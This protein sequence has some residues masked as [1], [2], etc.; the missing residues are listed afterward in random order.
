[1]DLEIYLEK[2]VEANAQKYFET[3]KKLRKKLEGAGKAI[4]ETRKKLK[5][6]AQELENAE[7][8][9]ERQ[10]KEK[11]RKKEW[12][13]K[14]RWFKSSNDFLIIGGKD[15]TSNEIVI[16]KHTDPHD[17]VFHTEAPG[18]PF[19]VIKNPEKRTIQEE[20]KKEAAIF[21]ATFSRAWEKGMKRAE[22]FEVKPE[23]VSKEAKSGEYITKGAF[24]IQGPK[25]I[26]DAEL[27]LSIG[28][29]LDDEEQKVIMAGPDTAVNKHCKEHLILKQGDLKKGEISK[30]IM[31][32]FELGTNDDILS[33]LPA[34]EFAL[35]N[36]D[37]TRK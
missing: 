12:Y 34:G 11:T 31:K 29:Y 22:V 27:N 10:K 17:V 28:Y 8:K 15:A 36:N 18:S 7:I 32:K 19:I 25:K 1:M 13:E 6:E 26:H 33:S 9:S 5:K 37:K 35:K 3:A 24:I 20:T 30:L 2:N 23:Q 21:A 14:F 16:K 4:E